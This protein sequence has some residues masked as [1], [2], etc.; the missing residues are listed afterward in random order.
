MDSSIRWA[1]VGDGCLYGFEVL[2]GLAE[3]LC[4]TPF[5]VPLIGASVNITHEVASIQV[6]IIASERTDL[7]LRIL[8]LGIQGFAGHVRRDR[9][10][11]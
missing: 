2:P 11:L 6:R 10:R 5:F 7:P 9:R 4:V 8:Q 1:A 3:P